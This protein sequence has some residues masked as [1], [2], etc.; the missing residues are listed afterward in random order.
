MRAILPAAISLLCSIIET[1]NLLWSWPPFS[2]RT[3]VVFAIQNDSRV[4]TRR[5]WKILLENPS[6]I[7]C[8][9]TTCYK[10][11]NTINNQFEIISQLATSQIM[12]NLVHPFM[13]FCVILKQRILVYNINKEFTTYQA[14]YT[15]RI[16]L[17]YYSN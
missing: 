7:R 3:S 17:H 2:S 1:H 5:C 12:L 14:Q 11:M 10:Y 15:V 4:K 6:N 8:I 13:R 16:F 9:L